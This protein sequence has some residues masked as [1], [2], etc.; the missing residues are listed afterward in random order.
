MAATSVHHKILDQVQT[1][2]R[3]LSLDGIEDARVVIVAVPEASPRYVDGLPCIAISPIGT[4]RIG[5]GTNRSDDIG[6]PVVVAIQA[7][8][9]ENLVAPGGTA[10]DKLLY[11]REQIIDKYIHKRVSSI[12]GSA[13]AKISYFDGGPIIDVAAW[14][15][16][17][18][19]LSILHLRAE[20]RKDRS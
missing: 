19:F 5:A 2:I 16:K 8:G 11:W 7:K 14:Y 17:Q 9:N 6:Y 1:D 10:L 12:T 4:E 13:N 15:A 3:G 18:V 20:I